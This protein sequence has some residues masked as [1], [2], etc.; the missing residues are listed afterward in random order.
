[1]Y[2]YSPVKTPLT[3]KGETLLPDQPL[4]IILSKLPPNS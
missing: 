3:P 1:M 2:R 4:T